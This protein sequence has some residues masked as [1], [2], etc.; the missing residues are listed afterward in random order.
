MPDGPEDAEPPSR[1]TLRDR[2]AKLVAGRTQPA[3]AAASADASPSAIRL[4][5]P[6]FEGATVR[7]VMTSRVDI[8][9]IEINATLEEALTL[10]ARE[11]HS[12]MPV[13]EDTLDE[14]LGF[15]HIKDIVAE[16]VR[17]G[18]T[19]D[20]LAQRPLERL[21][22]P[23]MY[24]PETMRLPDL[25]VQMQQARIHIALAVDEYGGIGGVV[26]LEDLVEE[27][28]GD[29]EDEHD[30]TTTSV[31]RKSRSVWDVDGLAE[32]RDVERETRLTLAVAQFEE[33]VATIGGLVAALAGRLPQAGEVIEHPAG[34]MLEVLEADPRRVVRVRL[35]TA[36][37][38][39]QPLLAEPK[40]DAIDRA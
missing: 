3:Q 8:A 38:P 6:E 5:I 19:S 35:R 33:D 13:Y 23:I 28:V 34:P 32:V 7:D 18:W 27:I 4:R 12:R 37:R 31:V 2:L 24:A 30:V 26:C 40:S 20:A 29:I 21:V 11:S 22:R 39:A 9:A 36:A 16:L 15:V 17:A 14:P 1:P 25:M 10:F